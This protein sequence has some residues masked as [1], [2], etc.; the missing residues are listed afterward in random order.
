MSHREE[1][2]IAFHIKRYLGESTTALPPVV[3]ERLRA[4]RERALDVQ[5]RP[6]SGLAAAVVGAPQALGWGWI[7]QLAPLVVL[8]GGLLAINQWHQ[9]QQVAEIAD[10][11]TQMLV[12]ELPPN[13]YL[14]KGFG[15]WLV[16]AEK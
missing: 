11:D 6:S 7:G 2:Q 16:Q 12:D 3:G 14:D 13:A 1:L 9:S 10:I 8:A 4:A 5:R 15:A